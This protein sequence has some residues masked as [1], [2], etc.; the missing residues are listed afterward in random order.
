MLASRGIRASKTGRYYY[1]KFMQGGSYSSTFSEALFWGRLQSLN[2]KAKWLLARTNDPSAYR[3]LANRYLDL[4]FESYPS[5]PKLTNE[6][7]EKARE[8]GH[9]DYLPRFATWKGELIRHLIGWKAA[10]RL[11][12]AFHQRTT[13]R[14]SS[15]L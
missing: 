14:R 3:A 12:A 1:R 2:C 4:A 13:R 15:F 7:L 10:K 6:A 11:H 9:T 8:M 5:F